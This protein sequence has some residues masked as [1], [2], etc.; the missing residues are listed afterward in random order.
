MKSIKK[1]DYERLSQT[2]KSIKKIDYE[3]RRIKSIDG[4]IYACIYHGDELVVSAT[5]DY[6]TNWIKLEFNNLIPSI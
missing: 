5:L 3:I 6:C 4:I 1:I 2:L